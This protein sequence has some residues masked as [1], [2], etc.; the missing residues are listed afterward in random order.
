MIPR[1][2]LGSKD[3]NRTISASETGELFWIGGG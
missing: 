2:A 3:I 1:Q